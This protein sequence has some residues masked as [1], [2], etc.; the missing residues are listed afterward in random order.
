MF[1]G[2]PL[3]YPSAAALVFHFLFLLFT[4][5]VHKFLLHRV[6]CSQ[7]LLHTK[8]LNLVFASSYTTSVISFCLF[9]P[10]TYLPCCPTHQVSHP[11]FGFLLHCLSDVIPLI[12]SY[13]LLS[14]LSS[15]LLLI[16]LNFTSS[17]RSLRF[18]LLFHLSTSFFLWNLKY[19]PCPFTLTSL[20][21]LLRSTFLYLIILS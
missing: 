11:G 20:S 7:C 9:P 15:T 3:S 12:P 8:S 14:P 6:T 10:T 18:T 1:Y 4:S 19:F 13:H 21:S 5:N 2:F 17:H 16:F